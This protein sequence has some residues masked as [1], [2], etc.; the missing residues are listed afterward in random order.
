[1]FFLALFDATRIF[2]ISLDEAT[3]ITYIYFIAVPAASL[4]NYF[5]VHTLAL[6]TNGLAISMDINY[7]CWFVAITVYCSCTSN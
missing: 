1:M 6:G 4:L 3:F 5:F 7:F 2:L